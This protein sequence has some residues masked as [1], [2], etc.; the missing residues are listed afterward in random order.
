MSRPT[1]RGVRDVETGVALTGASYLRG[2]GSERAPAGTRQ[3]GS[4]YR[5]ATLVADRGGGSTGAARFSG[6]AR[7]GVR[8]TPSTVA[9]FLH[10]KKVLPL[11]V[12][13]LALRTNGVHQLAAHTDVA[14]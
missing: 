2:V 10:R 8:K 3:V 11:G 12:A 4:G 13:H 6:G 5:K 1:Y 7:T 9:G 14:D